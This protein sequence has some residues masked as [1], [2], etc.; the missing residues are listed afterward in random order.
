MI[1]IKKMSEARAE[2]LWDSVS[3]F[4]FLGAR[5]VFVIFLK[6]LRNEE[7]WIML[8]NRHRERQS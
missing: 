8:K 7:Y 4:L 1:F 3:G 5:A 2:S 6:I